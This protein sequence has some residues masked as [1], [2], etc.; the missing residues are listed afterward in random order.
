[1]K[2]T[3]ERRLTEGMGLGVA[4]KDDVQTKKPPYQFASNDQTSVPLFLRDSRNCDQGIRRIPGARSA[5]V[6]GERGNRFA[7]LLNRGSSLE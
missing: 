1:M 2:R 6:T 7:H 3:M 5:T 4:L